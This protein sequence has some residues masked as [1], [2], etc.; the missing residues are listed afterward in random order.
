M[1]LVQNFSCLSL[2]LLHVPKVH[3][4]LCR[5]YPR[6]DSNSTEVRRHQTEHE[7]KLKGWGRQQ[8]RERGKAQRESDNYTKMDMFAQLSPSQVIAGSFCA[9]AQK[10]FPPAA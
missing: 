8:I 7:H 10:S 9:P 6:H 3:K 5:T 4:V 1:L 2:V